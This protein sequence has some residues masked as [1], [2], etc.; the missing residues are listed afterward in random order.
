MKR[1][2][3]RSDQAEAAYWREAD[4]RWG[5]SA[6]LASVTAQAALMPSRAAVRLS[7]RMAVRAVTR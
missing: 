2:T 6:W 4:V 7:R 5:L 3:D 1:F